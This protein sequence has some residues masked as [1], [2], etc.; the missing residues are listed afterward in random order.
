MVLLSYSILYVVDRFVC[1][2]VLI[3]GVVSKRGYGE[4]RG[5]EE[6]EVRESRMVLK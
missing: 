2:G 6:M 5:R 3:E 4:S 1:A